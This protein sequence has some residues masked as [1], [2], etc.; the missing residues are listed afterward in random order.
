[1]CLYLILIS[2]HYD[3]QCIYISYPH[4]EIMIIDVSISH[5]HIKPWWW[6]MW[7]Y[8]ISHIHIK[9]W[10]SLFLYLTSISRN[11][12][13]QYIY[14]SYIKQW[15]WSIYLY[16]ISILSND[17]HQYIYIS[18]PYQAL[19]M[20][21]ASISHIHIKQWS[22]RLCQCLISISSNDDDDQCFHISFSSFLKHS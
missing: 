10:F 1:M 7:Q 20:I 13:D 18:Y 21:I 16:L 14:I 8:P 5:I 9:Q 19:M 12:D 2:S 11:D 6:P 3:D 15:R 22:R 4:Q 17:D